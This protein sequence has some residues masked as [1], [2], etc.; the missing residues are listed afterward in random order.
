MTARP[1]LRPVVARTEDPENAFA[2]HLR[3]RLASRDQRMEE[4][5]PEALDLE[6][7]VVAAMHQELHGCAAAV[8][9][10]ESPEQFR[11]VLRGLRSMRVG[12]HLCRLVRSPRPEAKRAVDALL[13]IL[14]EERGYR[15]EPM[16]EATSA[17]LAAAGGELVRESGDVS[18]VL[19]EVLEDGRV[20][21]AEL[22][23]LKRE[24]GEM[25]RAAAKLHA[26]IAALEARK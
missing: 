14:A 12:R 9:G 16:G 4:R 19:M 24:V 26:Q 18:A 17:S 22:E 5:Y 1:Q 23:R 7:R 21:A 10:V 20:D 11:E 3:D 13:R 6:A 2:D 8:A 25:D 15:I